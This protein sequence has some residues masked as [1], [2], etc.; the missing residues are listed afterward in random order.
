MIPN[1]RVQVTAADLFLALE[2][3]L[4]VD[5]Q[6]AGGRE[7]RLGHRDRNQHRPLSSDTPRA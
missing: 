3:E 4:D 6:P 5:R 7:E 2:Q 1:E